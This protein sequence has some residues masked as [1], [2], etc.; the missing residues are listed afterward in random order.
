MA[1]LRF[2][3]HSRITIKL[4]HPTH[5]YHITILKGYL[6]FNIL[7]LFT[8][9]WIFGQH[10]FYSY[11]PKCIHAF[12]TFVCIQVEMM[13]QLIENFVSIINSVL[14]F[15][16]SIRYIRLNIIINDVISICCPYVHTYIALYE[17]ISDGHTYDKTSR[18]Q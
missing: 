17:F 5:V 11:T 16:I 2:L 13:Y 8:C 18:K 6:I 10:T 15:V 9:T 14:L 1:I 7:R 4:S 12:C 3:L